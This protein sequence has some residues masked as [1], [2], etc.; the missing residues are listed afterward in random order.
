[1]HR[2]HHER[3]VRS[4]LLMAHAHA[5]GLEIIHQRLWDRRAQSRPDHRRLFPK[6]DD[7]VFGECLLV[8]AMTC[9]VTK[10]NGRVCPELTFGSATELPAISSVPASGKILAQT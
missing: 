9:G 3:R 2:G 10:A 6:K 4:A 5:A 8:R 1:M 7:L